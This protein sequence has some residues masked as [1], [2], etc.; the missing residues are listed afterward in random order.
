MHTGDVPTGAPDKCAFPKG[1]LRSTGCAFIRS[2]CSGLPFFIAGRNYTEGE[3]KWSKGTNGLWAATGWISHQVS[4]FVIVLLYT[5]W[6]RTFHKSCEVQGVLSLNLE[7]SLQLHIPL[8]DLYFCTCYLW[9]FLSI[10][11]REHHLCFS[12]FYRQGK[13]ALCKWCS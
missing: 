7:K 2:S 3:G 11:Y 8:F 13:S 9:L 5:F 10:A 1:L 4:C 6:C 12:F